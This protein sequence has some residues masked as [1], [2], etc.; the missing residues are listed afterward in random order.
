MARRRFS[1]KKFLLTA[2][3]AGLVLAA[4]TTVYLD[5]A[6]RAR[7]EG[8]RFALPAK[9]YARPLELYPGLTL[10]P[11][12]MSEELG[13]LDYRRT[14]PAGDPGTY[15]WHGRDLDLVT[16]PFAFPDGPQDATAVRVEFE[17]GRVKALSGGA[18]DKPLHLVRLDP[19]LIGGIYPGKYEDRDPGPARRSPRRRGP[20]PDRRGGPALLLPPRHRPAGDLR[21]RCSRPPAARASRAGAP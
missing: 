19:P 1:R 18:G 12:K 13:L 3:L 20:R 7:F 9:V 6:V 14:S 21:G 4:C 5:F 15:C 16:R 8:R 17:D 10:S 2:A 11:A